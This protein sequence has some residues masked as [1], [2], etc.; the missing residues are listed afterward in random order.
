M[1]PSKNAVMGRRR[2]ACGPI[3]LACRRTALLG[4]AEPTA[5][6]LPGASQRVDHVRGQLYSTHFDTCPINA[7][8][9]R[10]VPPLLTTPA[11]L[12]SGTGYRH[13][14]SSFVPWLGGPFSE[15]HLEDRG[16]G[17]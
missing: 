3:L 15:I 4:A 1:L 7:I 13:S 8:A 5:R 16:V 12:P 6:H 10:P 9:T 14:F 17:S 2:A 11:T